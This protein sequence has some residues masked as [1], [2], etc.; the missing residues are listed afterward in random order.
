MAYY[1]LVHSVS[2]YP[3]TQDEW[4]KSWSAVHQRASESTRWI[5]SF[6]DAEAGKL[7]CEWEAENPEDILKCISDDQLR[8][9]PI[10]A[11]REIA[12]IDP[13]WLKSNS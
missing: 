5:H 2:E 8:M 9:A 7:Y 3:G 6:F 1:L 11:I 10:E 12:I 4:V 13:E